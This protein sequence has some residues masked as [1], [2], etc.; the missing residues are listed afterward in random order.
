MPVSDS[1]AQEQLKARRLAAAIIAGEVPGISCRPGDGFSVSQGRPYLC[2]PLH[3]IIFCVTL[4]QLALVAIGR[5]P[6]PMWLE[7]A[8]LVGAVALVIYHVKGLLGMRMMDR[9]QT[10]LCRF[11]PNA[12]LLWKIK[13]LPLPD[14]WDFAPKRWRSPSSWTCLLSGTDQVSPPNT[15]RAS[16]PDIISGA[17][18]VFPYPSFHFCAS[19]CPGTPY[20]P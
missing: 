17:A 2:T 10:C 1:P 15:D 19:G 13:F 4:A 3:H 8:S 7:V 12:F 6:E 11:R 18:P 16:R 20:G 14:H 5:L 9:D